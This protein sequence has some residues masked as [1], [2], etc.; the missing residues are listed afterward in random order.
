MTRVQ[1][2]DPV[3]LK[4]SLTTLIQKA[5]VTNSVTHHGHNVWLGPAVCVTYWPYVI[6]KLQTCK[7][8]VVLP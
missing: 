5:L 1:V 4:V 8:N 7:A 6:T 2:T 3:L